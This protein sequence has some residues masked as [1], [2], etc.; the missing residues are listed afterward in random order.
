MWNYVRPVRL[1]IMSFTLQ[2]SEQPH[3]I[4]SYPYIKKKFRIAHNLYLPIS[5]IRTTTILA[6][7]AENTVHII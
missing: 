6:I 3:S 7:V 4:V 2:T 1:N 5:I